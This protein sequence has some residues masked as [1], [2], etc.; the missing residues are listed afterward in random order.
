MPA[1]RGATRVREAGA[2]GPVQAGRLCLG[3]AWILALCLSVAAAQAE[4]A[5]LD[6]VL[7]RAD[8]ASL[9][10]VITDY[11]LEIVSVTG[12]PADPVILVELPAGGH[13]DALARDTR[14]LGAEPTSQVNLPSSPP[15]LQQAPS[16]GDWSADLS[17]QGAGQTACSNTGAVEVWSGYLE[18]QALAR[19]E[20][21]TAHTVSPD[22][23]DAVV[24]V[25]DTGV[26]PE[27]PVLQG[28]LL[29]GYDFLLDQGGIPSEWIQPDHSIQA[30]L[31]ETYRVKAQH[32]IQAILEGG[33]QVVPLNV[34]IRPILAP[35]M[36]LE[37]QPESTGLPEYFG[38]GTMVAGIVHLVAPSARIMPLRVFNAHGEAHLFDV[39]RAIYYA[40]DAGADVINMSFSMETASPELQRAVDYARSRGVVSVAAAGNQA[41]RNRVFPAALAPVVGVAST[42]LDDSLSSFSNYGNS[43]VDLAAPGSGVISIYPGGLYAIG[44]GTSFSA[45]FVA[46]AVA[47]VHRA[48]P[49]GD[50]SAFRDRIQALSKGADRLQGLSGKIGSGRLNALGSLAEAVQ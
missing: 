34:P 16:G 44:W 12:P 42:E 25:L 2:Q 38:H 15:S 27:H 26:D 43:L 47:L 39:L 35:G 5:A 36:D 23:G 20:L 40:V 3:L 50:S 1:W 24:A 11:G 41:D 6:R 48:L 4:G 28:A 32:S 49:E 10:S 33:G 14:I 17:L 37:A 13:L 21:L 46:G 8:P 19:I 29:P 45:P 18:Q 31:E 9:D 7:L 30:I 22:C